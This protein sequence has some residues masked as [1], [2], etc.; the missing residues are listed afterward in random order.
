[1]P[2]QQL[3]LDFFFQ[4]KKKKKKKNQDFIALAWQPNGLVIAFSLVILLTFAISCDCPD[5]LSTLVILNSATS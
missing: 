2:H 3:N 5:S 1:M 4:L